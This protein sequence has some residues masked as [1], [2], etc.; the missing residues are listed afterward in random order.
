MTAYLNSADPDFEQAFSA[1]LSAKRE[2]S[3][4]VN[5]RVRDIISDVQDR[6]DQALIELTAQLD[7]LDLSDETLRFSAEEIERYA[8]E[9]PGD[10]AEALNTAHDRIWAQHE[11]QKP[12][13]HIYED[14]LG[15]TLGTRWTPV[16]AVGLYVPGGLASYP[17]SVLMNAV[18]AKV[19]GVERIAIT[20][21]TPR[22]EVSPAV[23]LAAKI[24]GI[25]E[26]YRVGGAQAIAALAYGNQ[27]KEIAFKFNV[28][29]PTVDLH[30]A[31]LKRK[32]SAATLAEAVGKG[33]R[34]GIL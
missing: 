25:D 3:I 11:K 6:G 12:A 34:Y 7:Q 21:P 8:A 26:I 9:V 4:E 15:V 18:P 28:S 32:L 5:D 2:T 20:V 31:N 17:S 30:L 10:I 22:G 1:L 19:A 14:T 23:M 29:L 13:D 27:R 33:Y 16:D 24:A